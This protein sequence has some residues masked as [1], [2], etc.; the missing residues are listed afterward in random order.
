[1]EDQHAGN[2][3]CEVNTMYRVK[4]LFVELPG[5]VFFFALENSPKRRSEHCQGTTRDQERYCIDDRIYS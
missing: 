4:Q 2:A 5:F 3:K 1:M